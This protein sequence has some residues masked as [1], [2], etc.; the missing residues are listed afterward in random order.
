MF[1]CIGNVVWFDRL[2]AARAMLKLS[3]ASEDADLQQFIGS[4]AAEKSSKSGRFAT[5]D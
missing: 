4:A 5:A 2:S 1:E 3:R